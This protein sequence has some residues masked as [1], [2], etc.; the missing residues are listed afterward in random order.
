MNTCESARKGRKPKQAKV[1]V[2]P[3][4]KWQRGQEEDL[5]LNLRGQRRP[6]VDS[7]HLTQQNFLGGTW[8]PC[9][10]PISIGKSTA[11]ETDGD[12]GL[13]GWK[14]R[15]PCCN[16]WDTGFNVTR[17][18]KQAHVQLVFH[19]EIIRRTFGMRKSK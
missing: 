13:G 19:C 15:M 10:P 1:I 18:R 4:P 11:R 17:L 7:R 2:T 3:E 5:A 16:G 6:P 9:I 14:K 12:A 8:K